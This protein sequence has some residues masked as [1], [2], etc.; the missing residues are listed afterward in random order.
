[1]ENVSSP[2]CPILGA[3][4]GRCPHDPCNGSTATVAV[5][6]QSDD[7]KNKNNKRCCSNDDDCANSDPDQPLQKRQKIS[8]FTAKA[9]LKSLAES[10]DEEAGAFFHKSLYVQRPLKNEEEDSE[11]RHVQIVAEF[12]VSALCELDFDEGG[13]LKSLHPGFRSCKKPKSAYDIRERERHVQFAQADALME[14]LK[15]FFGCGGGGG[16]D[17]DLDLGLGLANIDDMAEWGK[18]RLLFDLASIPGVLAIDYFEEYEDE[19]VNGCRPSAR[20]M[21][22]LASSHDF[23][24]VRNLSNQLRA[25][26]GLKENNFAHWLTETRHSDLHIVEFLRK[27]CGECF[28]CAYVMAV[29]GKPA[30]DDEDYAEY[31]VSSEELYLSISQQLA[32]KRKRVVEGVVDNNEDED[33]E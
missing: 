6:E 25:L 3:S 21:W 33:E 15:V 29:H 9:M 24:L 13:L 2:I 1:M 18:S 32:D 17:F 16:G 22:P 27:R 4:R 12:V 30:D 28:A 31:V 26:K 14:I 23:A 10:I 11:E 7:A 5:D 20:V 8:T 19:K